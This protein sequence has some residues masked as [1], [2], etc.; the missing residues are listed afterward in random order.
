M[1]KKRT[2]GDRSQRQADQLEKKETRRPEK[3]TSPRGE[4]SRRYAERLTMP[5]R[6]LR[7]VKRTPIAIGICESCNMQFG[8]HQPIEDDA[9][10][11]MRAAFDAHKCKREDASQAA[12]RIVD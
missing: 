12:A 11:E 8:S 5:K 3:G 10:E 9:E 4:P 6:N 1:S 7:V 2:K